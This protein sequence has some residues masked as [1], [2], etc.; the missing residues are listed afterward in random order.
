MSLKKNTWRTLA[1]T[2]SS[3]PYLLPKAI[4]YGSCRTVHQRNAL[5][6]LKCSSSSSFFLLYVLGKNNLSSPW[7]EHC[8]RHFFQWWSLDGFVLPM[9]KKSCGWGCLK[10]VTFFEYNRPSFPIVSYIFASQVEDLGIFDWA[11]LLVKSRHSYSKIYMDHFSNV[12]V[13]AS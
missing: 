4:K 7:K 2:F 13:F 1:W 9:T 3:K 8:Y 10:L 12:N 11:P 6:K 5:R